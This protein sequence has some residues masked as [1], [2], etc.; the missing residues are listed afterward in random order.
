MAS[1]HWHDLLLP[2]LPWAE[3]V[4]RP[5]LVYVFLLLMF[6]LAS[7]RELAQA[8]VFDF[9]IILLISNVVQNAMIGEDNSVVGAA[10]GAATL[11]WLSYLLNRMTSTSKR[12]REFL[13]GTP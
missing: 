2:H 7:K 10:A 9:L 5:V 1:M 8:T 11:L 4:I 13:E 6:R 3:K 12:A